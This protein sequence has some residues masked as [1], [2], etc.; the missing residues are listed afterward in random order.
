MLQPL[1]S[2]KKL[3]ASPT[4]AH[5]QTNQGADLHTGTQTEPADST[6]IAKYDA[7]NW[8]M[9]ASLLLLLL[10]GQTT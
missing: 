5:M 2:S 10:Q 6:A 3:W 7:S 9:Q 1:W 4:L 8:H